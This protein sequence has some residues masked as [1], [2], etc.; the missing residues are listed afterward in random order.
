MPDTPIDFSLVNVERLKK[1]NYDPYFGSLINA[2]KEVTISD[3]INRNSPLSKDISY[4]VRYKDPREYRTLAKKF[5]LMS[6]IR[7]GMAR[8][9]YYGIIPFRIDGA[10]VYAVHG[11]LDLSKPFGS[12][13]TSEL[14][15]DD[16]DKMIRYLDFA[17]FYCKPTKWTGKCDPH[18]PDMIA[19]FKKRGQSK[20]LEAWGEMMVI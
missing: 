20:R 5:E 7:S 14:Y 9:A 8:T 3:L 13:P 16:W 6:D 2:A 1:E 11:D 10:Q 15:N 4:R 12:F 17:E 18:D 19:W